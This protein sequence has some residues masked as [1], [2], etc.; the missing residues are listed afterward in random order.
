M[1]GCGKK[2]AS[3]PMNN[4]KRLSSV[5]NTAQM[6]TDSSESFHRRVPRTRDVL[7]VRETNVLRGENNQW[8]VFFLNR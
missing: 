2:I 4:N 6:T 7:S 8:I 3:F 5:Q 1:R